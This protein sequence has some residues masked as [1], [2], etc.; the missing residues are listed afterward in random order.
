MFS[1][2]FESLKGLGGKSRGGGDGGSGAMMGSPS[3]GAYSPTP[4]P[5][6]T[7]PGGAPGGPS[8]SSPS[9]PPDSLATVRG[10]VRSEA[11][12]AIAGATVTAVE[13]NMTTTTA[14]DGTY[15]LQG[16]GGQQV[17]VQAEAS[18]YL[19]KINATSV[20]PGTVTWQNFALKKAP[21]TKFQIAPG[22][23]QQKIR[24]IIPRP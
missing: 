7:D 10:T 15:Y 24:P 19:K 8:P 23:G 3:G 18:G 2:L 22:L 16:P 11:G 4:A 6:P 21:P 12:V 13:W 17:T 14:P 1:K 5:S 20:P 9:A